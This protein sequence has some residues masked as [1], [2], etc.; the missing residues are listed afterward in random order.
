MDSLTEDQQKALNSTKMEMRIANEIYIREHK[1]LKHLVSHFMSKI[2][3]EKPDDTVAFA[4]TY[5]TT[6]GLE[7]VIKEDIGN[8][9]TFGC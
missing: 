4:A 5:F 3:Q 9:S 8:P 7:E 1:E 2:L 6:P